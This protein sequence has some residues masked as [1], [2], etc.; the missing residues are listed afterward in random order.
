M[1]ATRKTNITDMLNHFMH[2]E[3]KNEKNVLVR[4][5]SEWVICRAK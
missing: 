3:K 1:T 4:I 2:K 5:G